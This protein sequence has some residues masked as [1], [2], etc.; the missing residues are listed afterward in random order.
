MGIVQTM[1]VL[2]TGFLGSDEQVNASG[3]LVASLM[4]RLPQYLD[5]L[6]CVVEK[7]A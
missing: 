4:D 6:S 3:E 5:V 1:S 2:V 7:T